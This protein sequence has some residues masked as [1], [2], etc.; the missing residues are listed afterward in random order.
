MGGELS[1]LRVC[2]TE[3]ERRLLIVQ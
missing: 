2:N 3:T 1:V